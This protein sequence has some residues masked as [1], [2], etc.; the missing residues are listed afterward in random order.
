MLGSDNKLKINKYD[1]SRWNTQPVGDSLA[2]MKIANFA[3]NGDQKKIIL[4]DTS[5]NLYSGSYNSNINSFDTI[6]NFAS[7]DQ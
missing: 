2:N 4:A 3:L 7:N 1:G 6:K 5:N